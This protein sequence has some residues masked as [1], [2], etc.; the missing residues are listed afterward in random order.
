MVAVVLS[1]PDPSWP[2][3]FEE[4]ADLVRAA[5]SGGVVRIDHIGS[6]AVPGLA[7]KD[8]IDLQATVACLA[9][10]D[11]WPDQLGPFRRLGYIEDHVPP[12]GTPGPEW[13]KRYWCAEAP[14]AHLHVREEGR[15]NQRYALLFRD[16]LRAHQRSAEA[17]ERAKRSLA[18]VCDSSAVYADAKDPVC[19]LIMEAAEAWA[20]ATGWV[21]AQAVSSPK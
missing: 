17:Y 14:R 10:A 5:V 12:G 19:D 8:V 6:T 4:L 9:D 1:S 13:S 15:A 3:Q 18:D 11:A 21:P 16:Y 20:A 2:A 7:S